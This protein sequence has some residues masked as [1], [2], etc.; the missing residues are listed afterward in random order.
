M[1]DIKLIRENP[2]LVRQS[3]E[4]RGKP[5]PLDTIVKIDED[6]RN[7]L[8]Q[9]ELLRAK[10]NQ[11]SKELGK[12]ALEGGKDIIEEGK[13]LGKGVGDALKGLF[14]GKKKD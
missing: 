6:Y 7:L 2:E 1:I 13:D 3:L 11:T 10:H 4:K 8:Q 12:D 14:G 5:F 9:V